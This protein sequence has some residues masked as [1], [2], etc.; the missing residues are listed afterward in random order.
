[1]NVGVQ[2]EL[3]KIRKTAFDYDMGAVSDIMNTYPINDAVVQ[4]WKEKVGGRQTIVFCSTV[5]HAR[6][7]MASFTNARIATGMIWMI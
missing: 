6:D 5:Y 3:S 7:I 4:H 2:E 1:M